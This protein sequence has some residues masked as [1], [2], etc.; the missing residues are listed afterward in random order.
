LP[1][2]NSNIYDPL[3]NIIASI[4]YVLAR[5]GS[6]PAGMR[7]VAYDTGGWLF[8]W[9]QAAPVNLLGKPEPVL[10]P[11]QWD[12]AE[13]AIASA[14]SGNRNG[15]IQMNVY[16]QPGQSAGDLAR[17]MDRRLAFSGGRPA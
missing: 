13:S 11:R 8:P 4:R 14:V 15:R 2:Y 16:Q 7:G 6:I 17:E 5:Y 1:G 10:S 12:I 3:S 9:Q